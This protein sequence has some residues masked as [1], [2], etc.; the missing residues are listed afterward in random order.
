MKPSIFSS[1]ARRSCAAAFLA[2]SCGAALAHPGVAFEDSDTN[3]NRQLCIA[4]ILNGNHAWMRNDVRLPGLMSTYWVAL[5]NR[6]TYPLVFRL[7]FTLPGTSS[8][9]DQIITMK[10][11]ELKSFQ[12]GV[13]YKDPKQTPSPIVHAIDIF[14]YIQ[15][16]CT[17]AMG[18]KL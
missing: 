9:T 12:L 10:P 5:E 6:T 1:L 16:T 4:G 15:T 7:K 8:A 17:E 18:R 13:I 11:Q 3:Y 2:L 14:K